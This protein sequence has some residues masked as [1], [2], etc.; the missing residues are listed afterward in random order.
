MSMEYKEPTHNPFAQN[1]HDKAQAAIDRA[2]EIREKY[3]AGLGK[4]KGEL[5]MER[6]GTAN[7]VERFQGVA[8]TTKV[9]LARVGARV[10][11]RILRTPL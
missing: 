1:A 10:G 7:E 4:S 9:S 3:V 6:L 8:P 11:S 2:R 5:Q